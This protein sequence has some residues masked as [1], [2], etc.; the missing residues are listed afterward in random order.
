MKVASVYGKV[1]RSPERAT[2]WKRAIDALDPSVERGKMRADRAI[3]VEIDLDQLWRQEWRQVGCARRY[4]TMDKS[5][6]ELPW[7]PWVRNKHPQQPPSSKKIAGLPD[8]HPVVS[9][10]RV[11]DLDV[12]TRRR[13]YL[14]RIEWLARGI[15][16]SGDDWKRDYLREARRDLERF[17]RHYGIE[18]RPEDRRDDVDVVDQ[19][20]LF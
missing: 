2:E 10:V 15:L 13:W 1:R 9:L 11:D 12:E 5:P 4:C 14:H 7:T 8:D 20:S 17:D 18:T 3:L 6:I 16:R 19:K